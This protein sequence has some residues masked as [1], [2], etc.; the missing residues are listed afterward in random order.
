[1]LLTKKKIMKGWKRLRR[2]RERERETD[3]QRKREFE[4]REKDLQLSIENRAEGDINNLMERG[5]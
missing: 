4:E 2:K 5:G 3:R 1:M